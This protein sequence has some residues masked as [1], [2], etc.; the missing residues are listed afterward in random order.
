MTFTNPTLNQPL[1]PS[2]STVRAI[3]PKHNKKLPIS[4][5]Q[6]NILNMKQNL[7]KQH[8]NSMN[9]FKKVDT[10]PAFSQKT[11]V[12]GIFLTLVKTCFTSDHSLR[13]ICN[14]N[15]HKISYMCTPNIGSAISSHNKK[16]LTPHTP[17]ESN[18]Y[19]C[20]EK[21]NCPV[22]GKCQK[23]EVIYRAKVSQETANVNTFTGLTCNTF[24]KRWNGH[25]YSFNHPEANKSTLTLCR[26]GFW[27]LVITRGGRSSGPTS[28]LCPLVSMLNHI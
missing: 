24:K 12:G 22:S 9:P 10:N 16:L 19:N 28:I 26:P 13:K 8:P 21:E 18:K 20:K 7:K 15:K 1:L 3:T 5:Y 17:K 11:N 4:I 27:I 23:I 14:R 25:I 6:E 2:T